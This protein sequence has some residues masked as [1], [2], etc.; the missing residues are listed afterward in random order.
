[1]SPNHTRLRA[2]A[3]RRWGVDFVLCER[4]TFTPL[5]VIELDDSSHNRADRQARDDFKNNVLSAAGLP[6]L[7]IPVRRHYDL[8]ELTTSIHSKL[9]TSISRPS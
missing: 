5:L 8:V 7:R 2:G 4:D 9:P 6:L 3:Y 1:M